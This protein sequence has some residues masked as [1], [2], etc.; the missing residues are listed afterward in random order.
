MLLINQI[1]CRNQMIIKRKALKYKTARLDMILKIIK[2]EKSEYR[3]RL[4][5]CCKYFKILF[6]NMC[7]FNI[8]ISYKV[9]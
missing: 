8:L 7:K 4:H 5:I 1:R 3:L 9:F 2:F 6:N